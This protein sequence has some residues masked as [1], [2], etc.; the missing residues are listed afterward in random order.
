MSTE[1]RQ[2]EEKE[3]RR[4]TIVD[5]AE[6]VLQEKG[7]DDM[8]MADI[9]DEARL[10]RSLLYV[11]FEDMDDI[12]LGVTHRGLQALRER[13][14]AA[15]AAHET[16]LRQI[17]AIGEAY[18]AFACEAPTHFDLVAQFEARPAAPD[19]ATERERQCLAEADRV[20]EAMIDAIQRGIDDGSIRSTLDPTRTAL[21]LW[22]HTHGL[23]QLAANKGPGLE[24]RYGLDAETLVTH[25]LDF[26]GVALT[27]NRA[28]EVPSADDSRPDAS[29]A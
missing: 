19:D 8:T 7:R 2:Q 14:E 15:A 5:A 24:Q 17:R 27:G 21:T 16:G 11:Y 12:V 10:S 28:E 26:A 22:G 1:E 9:A 23:I 25:G 18:V 6:T 3:H 4:R 29:A 13:F 20:M